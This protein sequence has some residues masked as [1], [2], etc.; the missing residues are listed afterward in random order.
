MM[1]IDNHIVD[2]NRALPGPAVISNARK[3]LRLKQS[4]S[5]K[6][7]FTREFEPQ[8]LGDVGSFS[9]RGI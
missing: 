9:S 6:M 5:S 3:E 7:G 8:M 4:K 1:I 2:D